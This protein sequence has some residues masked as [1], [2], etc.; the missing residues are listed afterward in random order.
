MQRPD[1]LWGPLR[2]LKARG[3][4]WTVE[5]YAAPGGGGGAEI[6]PPEDLRDQVRVL[7]PLPH[8][9]ALRA[10]QA[11]TALLVLAWETR[12]GE[13]SVAGKLFEYVGSGRPVL[14]CAPSGF[15]ARTFV[16]STGTGIG[17]WGEAE[18]VDALVRLEG[19]VV[20]PAGRGGLRRR[21][22]AEQLLA[23]FAAAR[24]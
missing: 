3:R 15:E 21:R 18:T 22:S 2:T 6:R 7:P 17:A 11:M 19:Y 13:T 23:L 16:E 14:V 5:F 9:R 12:G 4:P 1:R 24:G 20:A 8:P 10:M